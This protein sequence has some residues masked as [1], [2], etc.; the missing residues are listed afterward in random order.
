MS[1]VDPILNGTNDIPSPGMPAD[2]VL[3]HTDTQ[4]LRRASTDSEGSEE[5]TPSLD[6]IV[7]LQF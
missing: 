1:P 7:S 3:H 4:R 6:V 2:R 5:I